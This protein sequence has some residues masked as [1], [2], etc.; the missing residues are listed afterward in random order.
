MELKEAEKIIKNSFLFK[1]ANE[2]I[3][4]KEAI[5]TVLQALEE[6]QEESKKLKN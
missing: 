6:L 1:D 5:S 4:L 3:Q 2:H